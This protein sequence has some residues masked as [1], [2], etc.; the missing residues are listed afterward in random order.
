M[1]K[2]LVSIL[3]IF[4]SIFANYLGYGQNREFN[5]DI[6][7]FDNK[8]KQTIKHLSK[9]QKWYLVINNEEV[10]F[11]YESN[12]GFIFCCLSDNQISFLKTRNEVMFRAYNKK[13]C[14]AGLLPTFPICKSMK[15][16]DENV[17]SSQMQSFRLYKVKKTLVIH[18]L[19][20]LKTTDEQLAI[21]AEAKTKKKFVVFENQKFVNKRLIPCDE[22][23]GEY[24]VIK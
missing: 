24:D 16:D 2:I 1:Y 13:K 22:Y 4:L 19:L 6:V 7:Y 11:K 15:S 5:V 20:T 9:F 3:F 17:N 21:I 14:Y 12:K 10:E 23:L 8:S 18:Y